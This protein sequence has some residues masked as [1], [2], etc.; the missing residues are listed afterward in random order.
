M[1][2]GSAFLILRT[3][4]TSPS[5]DAPNLPVASFDPTPNLVQARWPLGLLP[6]SALAQLFQDGD[7]LAQHIRSAAHRDTPGVAAIL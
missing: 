5:G 6:P 2:S 7:R 4:P 1:P 3:P